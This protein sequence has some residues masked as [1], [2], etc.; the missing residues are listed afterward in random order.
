MP[1][2]AA[3]DELLKSWFLFAAAARDDFFGCIMASLVIVRQ[4]PQPSASSWFKRLESA[5]QFMASILR[6]T[7]EFW[8]SLFL[9][10]NGEV[11]ILDEFWL[12]CQLP[13]VSSSQ[14]RPR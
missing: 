14:T 3:R 4:Q 2:P 7:D 12:G 6:P 5:K 11:P 1:L 13:P 9:D 10:D 8:L